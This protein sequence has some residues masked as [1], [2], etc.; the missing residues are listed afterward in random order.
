MSGLIV[1]DSLDFNSL[2]KLLDVTDGNL[3][4]H[5]KKLEELGYIKYKK[6]FKGRMPNT[7]YSATPKGK[8]VFIKHL[9][10]IEKLLNNQ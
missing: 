7:N 4:T 6:E 2:K 9:K 5:L 10:A 8:E 1:N 3:A